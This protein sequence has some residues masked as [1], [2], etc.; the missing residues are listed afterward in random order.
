MTGCMFA[1]E[2]FSVYDGP[3]IRST[4]FL[5]GCPLR[6]VWCHNPEGQSAETEIVRSPNGCL[7]CGACERYA[8]LRNGRLTYTKQ[9]VEHC[10]RGLLRV[11]GE[12][13]EPQALCERLLK[14]ES[15]L[16]NGGVTFSGGEPLLQADFLF[17]CLSLLGGKLHTAVQ[18]CGY[19]P[20]EVFA[21]A[22]SL[23]DYFLYDLKL[24][25]EEQHK[26]YT[27]VSNRLILANFA[28]L[29]KSGVP[30]TLR[31]PL[32]PTVTD[33]EENL[34]ALARLMKENGVRYVELLPYNKMAGG[35]YKMLG[36]SY[37][38]DFDEALPVNTRDELFASFGIKTKVL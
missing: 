1:L 26:T 19:A 29:A 16:K 28:Q 12:S 37:S 13:I 18:T 20:K 10:P 2:E 6:C 30:F 7:S 9:S 15:I 34:T 36:R 35:K 4:V 17:A 31:V 5:K 38:P 14:N 27:G 22:L 23:S 25:D 3:G 33:T 24:I 32:I 21:K 11:C 8:V